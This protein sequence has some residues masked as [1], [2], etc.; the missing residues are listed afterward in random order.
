MKTKSTPNVGVIENPI[1]PIPPPPPAG[2]TYVAR[3]FSGDAKHMADLV[4]RGIEH[5]GFALIDCLSPC[6]TYNRTKTSDFFRER[7][8]DLNQEGHDPT[9]MKAAVARAL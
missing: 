8:Y 4:Q 2:A 7:V 9:D 6:V 1:D 3:A 5:R